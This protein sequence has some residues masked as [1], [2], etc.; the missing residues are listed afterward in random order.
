MVKNTVYRILLIENS[1]MVGTRILGLLATI[2][3]LELLGQSKTIKKGLQVCEL[4]NPDI[5]LLDINLPDGSGI[6]LIGELKRRWPQICIIMLTNSSNEFYR[7]KC[8][9][10][11]A[12]FFLDKTTDF[13]RIVEIVARIIT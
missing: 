10:L 8:A 4:T 9:E 3:S 7:N 12:E 6:S 5:V 1:E 13:P 11:G 2:P